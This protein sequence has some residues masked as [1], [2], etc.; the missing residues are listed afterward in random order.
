[1]GG[2]RVELDLTS[3]GILSNNIMK[4][5]HGPSV[6]VHKG[7]GRLEE[8]RSYEIL[9]LGNWKANKFKKDSSWPVS[10]ECQFAV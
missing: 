2:K 3:H 8:K 6:M 4:Q 9:A 1:M 5:V 7:R 10:L